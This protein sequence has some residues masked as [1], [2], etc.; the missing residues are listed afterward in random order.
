MVRVK[1]RTVMN[2]VSKFRKNGIDGLRDK[3]G[4]GS[5]PYIPREEYEALR[6]MVKELQDN[7]SGGRIRAKD[8]GDAIEKKFGKRPSISVIYK[9]LKRANLV[10]ITARSKHPKVDQKAQEAFK[11]TSRVRSCKFFQ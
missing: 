9:T 3:P 6:E 8:I 7:R 11:K 5:K 2:W 1:E 4:R 10:W